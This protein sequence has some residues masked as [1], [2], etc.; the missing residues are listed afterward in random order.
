[1]MTYHKRNKRKK[2]YPV[3]LDLGLLAPEDCFV[4]AKDNGDSQELAIGYLRS[5]LDHP[6]SMTIVF[7]LKF[8]ATLYVFK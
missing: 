1:M 2:K 3:F 8:K 5:V 7:R 4:R 6:V